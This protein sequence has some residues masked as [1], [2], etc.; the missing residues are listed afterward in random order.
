MDK[1][2]FVL[3]LRNTPTN[4]L[5]APFM[6]DETQKGR[7]IVNQIS[8]RKAMQMN[9]HFQPQKRVNESYKFASNI[10]VENGDLRKKIKNK[11][12][13]RAIRGW[14]SCDYYSMSFFSVT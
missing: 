2:C 12:F 11:T 1:H 7:S 3:I 4:S 13:V 9:L 5:I 14:K 10:F 8:F 6:Y